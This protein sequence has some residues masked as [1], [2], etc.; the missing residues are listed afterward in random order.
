MDPYTRKPKVMHCKTIIAVA[1]FTHLALLP[2]TSFAD[3]P[4]LV[5]D[6]QGH[7]AMI[8]DVMFT[9][10]GATLISVSDDKTIRLWNVETG[11]LIKTV[12][13]QI[14]AG[15][16]GKLFA[17]ALS[18][19]GKVLAVGGFGISGEYK[20]I[21]LYN[22]ESGE[23]IVLLKGHAK[24]I[25]DL[26][27]SPESRWLASCSSDKTVR[28]WDVA[29]RQEIAKLAGHTDRVNGV[30][31]SPDGKKVVSASFDGTLRLWNV[32]QIANVTY[33]EMKQHT[34]RVDC[35]AFAPDGQY[36]VSG[37]SDDKILLWDGNGSFVKEI[38]TYSG[39]VCT[40]SFS[41]D[42]KKIVICGSGNSN[43]LVY[44]IPSGE[45]IT[46]FSKHNNTVVASAFYGNDLIATAGGNNNDIY[47]WDANSGTVKTHIVGQG[48]QV[49]GIGLAF[50]KSLN[51][52]FGN[53]WGNGQG[54]LE[55]SFNFSVMSLNPQ[56][57]DESDFQRIRWK[58]SG[59]S[60]EEASDYEL[61]IVGGGTI[62]NDHGADGRVLCYTFT[63]D[64]DVL[65]GSDFSL[66]LYRSDGTFIRK[67]IGHTG[68]VWAVSVDL[69]GKICASASGDQTIKLWNIQSGELLA[70]L[71]M[72]NDNEWI[73]WTPQG[74]YTASAGGEK[75]IGWQINQGVDKAAKYYPVSTYRN[76]F[77]NKGLVISTID[78]ASF[79][80]AFA[81]FNPQPSNK[82]DF[83]KIDFRKY[84]WN[85]IPPPSVT[86]LSP[87]ANYTKT[88]ND[89]ITI[90]AKVTSSSPITT[91]KIQINGATVATLFDSVQTIRS[92]PIFVPFKLSN[93]S[94]RHEIKYVNCKV[95]LLPQK[96]EIRIFAANTEAFNT[97]NEITVFYDSQ[98]QEWKKPN[99]YMVSIGI[100]NYQRSNN[101]LKF[102]VDDAK[103]MVQIFSQQ[104]G[105]LFKNVVVKP[106][107]DGQATRAK[108]INA[109][110][111]LDENTTQQD[112]AVVF[113]SAHGYNA[114]DVF[115]ILPHDGDPDSL[116]TTG[117]D[118]SVFIKTLGNLSSRVVLFL[119]TCYSG[120]FANDYFT[121]RGNVKSSIDNTEAI[122]ELTSEEY[123]VVI[124]AAST[125]SEIS[126]ESPEWG[127]GAFTKAIIDG[128]KYGKADKSDD[129]I[130]NLQELD[131]YVTEQVKE[132]TKGHQH[133]KTNYSPSITI[134]RFPI[135][136]CE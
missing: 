103:E 130:I 51:V 135:F 44:S 94:L 8:R 6:P 87:T 4:I 93:P 106:L 5:I 123:G 61:R 77:L 100:S 80:K 40:V 24:V 12:R 91:L 17:G 15:P 116:M 21:H 72:T 39:I 104:N 35:V 2:K 120:Q 58:Y 122:R 101:N 3:D 125:G 127:H 13:G 10:N 128:L 78:S 79:N 69:S 27:F 28:I 68:P 9:P 65:V 75:Y 96:N 85:L 111:W 25:A 90:N 7:S 105:R 70:T 41:A 26:A 49:V 110:E 92:Y 56:T 109:L 86:W 59:K 97:S 113:L 31:F 47:I 117:V 84:L 33:A 16:E 136:Q 134:S 62:E 131:V 54:N 52:A 112:V 64:G 99:L 114:R 14:G 29:R 121:A 60:F 82:I 20:P 36:I 107:Y 32:G 22:I 118:W 71:F 37:G 18:P 67:F 83:N 38:D 48:K 95:P 74:Y 81:L 108:I 133:S 115:Y 34:D 30:T 129:G 45:K 11:D 43:A 46:T 102:A 19:N 50:G 1:L 66:K 126:Q 124:M 73:C 42:S 119:D 98:D 89:S 63:P 88:T 55:K 23:Q 53:T 132:L 57:P 76:R